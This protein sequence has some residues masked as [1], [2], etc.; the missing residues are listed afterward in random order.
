MHP[1][2][3]ELRELGEDLEREDPFLEP[4]T[5]LLEHVVADE[6][7]NRVADRT[8]LVVEEGLAALTMERLAREV[9]ISKALVYNYYAS[10]ETL[11]EAL[12]QREQDR[13]YGIS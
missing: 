4:V 8:L 7:A 12:L 5:D 6:L 9:G 2:Q 3:T 11:L 10:R 13:A 1:E